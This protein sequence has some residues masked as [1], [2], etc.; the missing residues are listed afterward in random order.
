VTIASPSIKQERAG[1]VVIAVVPSGKRAVKSLP[2]RVI[3]R[4]PLASAA[5]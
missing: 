2:F 3:S 5:P 4:T 1:S